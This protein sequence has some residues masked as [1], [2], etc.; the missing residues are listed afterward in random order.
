MEEEIEEKTS[1]QINNPFKEEIIPQVPQADSKYKN[2][3]LKFDS[4]TEGG[5]DIT[6]KSLNYSVT[7]RLRKDADPNE[8]LLANIVHETAD[9][10]K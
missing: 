8:H 9:L 5:F 6:I 2:L 1:T 4:N 7:Q 3:I 10:D